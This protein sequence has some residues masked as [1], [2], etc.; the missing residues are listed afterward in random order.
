[1]H[2]STGTV[3]ECTLLICK[4]KWPYCN[5][6]LRFRGTAGVAQGDRPRDPISNALAPNF[7]RITT[8]YSGRRQRGPRFV[9]PRAT[10]LVR[11]CR[12]ESAPHTALNTRMCIS[13]IQWGIQQKKG[14][15]SPASFAQELRGNDAVF[16]TSPQNALFRSTPSFSFSLLLANISSG[17]SRRRSASICHCGEP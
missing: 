7:L 6:D 14:R 17:I 2:R 16:D 5:M 3:H 1:M 13:I 15:I 11:P 9:E 12:Q 10:S 4:I 8:H